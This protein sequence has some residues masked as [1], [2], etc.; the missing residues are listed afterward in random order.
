M[1]GV[2]HRLNHTPRPISIPDDPETIVPSGWGR[3]DHATWCRLEAL[4][5]FHKGVNAYVRRNGGR[6]IYVATGDP[7]LSTGEVLFVPGGQG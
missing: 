1:Q 2:I 3:I 6:R 5:Q 4:R 7:M